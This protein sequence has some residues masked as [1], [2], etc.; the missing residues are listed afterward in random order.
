[1]RIKT[2]LLP[3]LAI[4]A[5]PLSAQTP[6]A[7]IATQ[8][9]DLL[10]SGTTDVPDAEE[11]NKL[12]TD[13]TDGQEWRGRGL[14]QAGGALAVMQFEQSDWFGTETVQGYVQTPCS[15]VRLDEG[16]FTVSFRA[17]SL[18]AENTTLKIELYDPYTTNSVDAKDVALGAEW[19]NVELTLCH[20]GYGN[21]LAYM[22]MAALDG[23]WLIDDFAITQV[24]TTVMPPMIHFAKNVTYT[25]FTGYWNPVPMATGYLLSAYSLDENKERVYLVK[26]AS[27]AEC[28]YKV[29]GT[30]KGT[31]YYYT[32][33]SVSELYTSVEA[34]ARA[35]NVPL[36]ALDKPVAL[37]AGGVKHDGFTARWEPVFRAM[38]YIVNLK[39]AH[40]AT[41]DEDFTVLREDFDK[42]KGYE[43]YPDWP[44]PFYENL[45]DYTTMPGWIAPNGPVT[46]D[47]MFGLDNMWK[48]Y[49]EISLTSP[50]LDL[51]ADGGSFRLALKVQGTAG[52]VLHATCGDA[53]QSHALEAD[54][55]EFELSFANGTKA[56]VVKFEF[57]GD[58]YLFFDDIAVVQTVHAGELVTENVGSVDTG[59]PVTEYTFTGLEANTGDIFEYT[60]TAW[61]YSLGEDG[62]WGPN[63][64]SE[65]SEPCRVVIPEPAGIGEVAAEGA[66]AITVEGGMLQ[67]LAPA[68]ASLELYSA[69]GVL[70]GRYDLLPGLNTLEAPAKGLLI[71][72]SGATVAKLSV[73]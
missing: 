35:V 23:N 10:T 72:R 58:G 73:R 16:T 27:T 67:V 54:T 14:H 65:A 37:E 4:G 36:T 15:D 59:E 41:G 45:D 70:L 55:E 48:Q 42:C 20:P 19:Q 50:A 18:D 17:R 11:L 26:D 44:V 24:Y 39:R 52:Q 1:M 38:G 69:A 34:E 3:M 6:V 31:Q 62:V 43:G 21:H 49:E 33:R 51:S 29:E 2:L 28:E 61:S 12:D 32:V 68:A 22:Q 46:L 47:G 8:N 56:T 53:V 25:E 60:V 40:V 66:M 9:F 7:T 30:V 64:Y 13:L 57:D 71:A 63:V 5:M